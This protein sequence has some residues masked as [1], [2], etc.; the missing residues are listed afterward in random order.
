M[1]T[2]LKDQPSLN[3]V[4]LPESCPDAGTSETKPLKLTPRVHPLIKKFLADQEKLFELSEALGSP[5]NLLFP[6][7]LRENV[8]AFQA[9]LDEFHIKGRIFFAHKANR[10]DSLTRQL[11]L[12]KAYIDVSSA[13]ELRHA[14]ASGFSASRIQSTGPKNDE[15]LALS[16]LQNV[17]ISIDSPWELEQLLL[18]RC[19]L[20]TVDKT[21]LLVRVSGFRSPHSNY[22]AKASR[23]GVPLDEM[24]ELFD[25]LQASSKHFDLLGFSFHVDTVSIPEKALAIENCLELFEEAVSRGFDPSVLNIGGGF[26]VNYLAEAEQW[27]S[28]TTAM[29]DAVLG[30]RKPITWQGNSFG[31][32][33]D[34]GRL[35]GNFNSYAYYDPSSGPKFLEELLSHEIAALG[36]KWAGTLL[37]ENGIDLWIEPGRALLDQCGITVARV[38]SLRK[39]SQGDTLVCLNMK[40]Q[41]LCFLDQE[42]FVD[43]I[44]VRRRQQADNGLV[45]PVYFAG[46]LCLESD[47]ISRHQIFLP[48]LPEPGDLVVFANTAGYFMDFS[49]SQAIMQ[50][51]ARKAAIFERNGRFSWAMDDQYQPW[52]CAR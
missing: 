34:S 15:F 1:T 26:K 48:A 2:S 9:T 6:E 49:A 40:R 29:R 8:A 33:A 19:R 25:F 11:A 4:T 50:P 7:L 43:P 45:Y 32:M 46:N 13:N 24:P 39:S 21:K 20:S 47:L 37:S 10:S 14:L 16:L 23:F 41:D 22:R 18:Q 35:R 44:I 5:L 42:I 31:L 27:H 3:H 36:D 30:T 38:N 52:L 12:E 17:I 51:T 28:Y